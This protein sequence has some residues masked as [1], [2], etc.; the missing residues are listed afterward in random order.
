[1]GLV[2]NGVEV[3]R[4]DGTPSPIGNDGWVRENYWYEITRNGEEIT[5]RFSNDGINYT[6]A[7]SASLTEP[8]TTT[9]RAI[10]D[11]ALYNAAGSYVDWDYIYVEPGIME[12]QPPVAL[13][14]DIIVPAGEQGQAEVT[15]GAIDDGSYDPDGDPLA[16]AISPAG[17]YPLGD[18]LV[19]LT[20]T[21]THGAE[22]SCSAKITVY[23]DTPPSITSLA[24]DPNSLWPANHKMVPVLQ[25]IFSP[26]ARRTILEQNRKISAATV[27]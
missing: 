21:D 13:C 3:A 22:A 1:M 12:N 7:F 14:R 5:V 27:G 4:F 26:A 24:A 8:V 18:T 17:P 16:Y 11:M 10:I 6:T 9:Q 25:S 19:T 2:R 15:P 20:V 23:D